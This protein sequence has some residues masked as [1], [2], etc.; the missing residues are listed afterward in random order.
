MPIGEAVGAPGEWPLWGWSGF[1]SFTDGL[2]N[3]AMF[4]EKLVGNGPNAPVARGNPASSRGLRLG[5]SPLANNLDQGPAGGPIPHRAFVQQCHDD[6]RHRDVE[7]DRVARGQRP[8]LDRW[9]PWVVPDLVLLQPFHAAQHGPV[10]GHQRCQH[11]GPGARSWTR[12]LPRAITRA[13]STWRWPMDLSGSSKTPSIN[14]RGGPW[15]VATDSEIISSDS[16]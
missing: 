3:T 6:P 8:L 4:S 1:A 10:C 11:R 14:K 13:E 2:S 5:W 12:F 9:K 16:Y 7:G 15:A